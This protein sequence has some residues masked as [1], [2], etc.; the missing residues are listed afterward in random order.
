MNNQLVGTVVAVVAQLR[1]LH[2]AGHRGLLAGADSELTAKMFRDATGFVEVFL[3]I[4]LSYREHFLSL[5]PNH[6]SINILFVFHHIQ[7]DTRSVLE[8]FAVTI[9]FKVQDFRGYL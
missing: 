9:N 2:S 3:F 7:I 8:R 5:C 4:N 6:D 1:R